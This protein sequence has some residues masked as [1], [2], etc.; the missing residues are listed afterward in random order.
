LDISNKSNI[1]ET[2]TGIT[3]IDRLLD[4]LGGKIYTMDS[5]NKK[6]QVFSSSYYSELGSYTFSANYDNFKAPLGNAINGNYLYIIAQNQTSLYYD[7]LVLDISN[8]SSISL[9]ETFN[10]GVYHSSYYN[11]QI[12]READLLFCDYNSSIYVYD[13]SDGISLK[14]ILSNYFM[15]R[16]LNRRQLGFYGDKVGISSSSSLTNKGRV[17]FILDMG[18][19]TFPTKTIAAD[20]RLDI[21]GASLSTMGLHQ[22][23]GYLYAVG[24]GAAYVITTREDPDPPVPTATFVPKV[25]VI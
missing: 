5:S 10:M 3:G 20:E 6:I 7:I 17:P 15:E 22:E 23:N 2:G 21:A 16:S 1:S 9:V 13:I 8:P 4:V 19:G 11:Y 25:M 12:N 24:D 18:Y 14:N